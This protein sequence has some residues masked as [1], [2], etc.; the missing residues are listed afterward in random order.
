MMDISGG[1]ISFT[2]DAEILLDSIVVVLELEFSS[3]PS[4][5]IALGQVAECKQAIETPG[6]KYDIGVECW[7][8]GWKDIDVQQKIVN[9]IAGS[10][11]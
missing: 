6:K 10:L 4:A 3:L 2:S 9:F 8:I 7:W 11:S 1:G 5:I